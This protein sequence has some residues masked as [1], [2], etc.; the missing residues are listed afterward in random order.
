MARSHCM[1][2]R[3]RAKLGNWTGNNGLLCRTV[4][5]ALEPGMVPD[6]LSTTVPV[7]CSVNV[8]RDECDDKQQQTKD[9]T[10]LYFGLKVI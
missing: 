1:G 9:C 8:P 3:P 2:A 6:P 4:H 5:T 10:R 7:P